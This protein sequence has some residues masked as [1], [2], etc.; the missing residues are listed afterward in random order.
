MR[1]DSAMGLDMYDLEESL[2]RNPAKSVASRDDHAFY[3]GI[4]VDI[5]VCLIIV[6]GWRR[7]RRAT[8]AKRAVA[9]ST[10][11]KE[12]PGDEAKSDHVEGKVFVLHAA[13]C[14]GDAEK[15]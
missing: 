10:T 11:E 13:V 3:L 6:E 4:C 1:S 7:F 14:N 12:P 9:P 8:K 15:C 2:H 5:L